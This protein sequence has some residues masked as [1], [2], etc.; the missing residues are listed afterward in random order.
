MLICKTPYRISFCGGGTDYPS[1]YNKYGGQVISTTIDKYIYITLR[2]LPPF[3]E[4]KHRIVY[5]KTEKV[6]NINKIQH[7][8][9]REILRYYKVKTGLEIHY[10]GDLPAR[11][12]LG[13]S[14]AFTVG[15][16]NS[17]SSNLKMR[18]SKKQIASEAI[19]IEQKMI[20]EIVGSQDQVATS[21]G[22]LNRI[23]F[24][25]NNFKV[26]K[27]NVSKSKLDL[28]EKNLLLI[29]TG[30]TRQA[31]K[32]AHSYVKKID[33]I[34]KKLNL[35]NDCVNSFIKT[36]TNG[37]LDDLG[38]L[39]DYSWNIKKSFSKEVSNEFL[40]KVYNIAKNNG[41]LGG[42]LLG[43]GAGGFFLFYAKKEN[44]S[45]ILRSLKN[46]TNVPFK[47]ENDGTK[48]IFSS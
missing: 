11:S 29:F 21:Y 26:K 5:A 33:L 13:S 44:H 35:I 47:F 39:L 6:N 36:L 32:V 23:M 24:T 8:S 38:Y 22:G 46:F 27:V 48:I 10:D 16:I 17:I 37:N 40:D 7:P 9:V 19:Y 31:P 41:A 43:A 42:K 15:L 34:D 18:K 20:K 45:K 14:S 12:G 1:W 28:F 3:F 30:V 2:Q 25:K 4:H